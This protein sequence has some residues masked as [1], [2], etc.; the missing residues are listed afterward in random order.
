M[1]AVALQLMNDSFRLTLVLFSL[2]QVDDQINWSSIAED[3]MYVS[4]KQFLMGM[5]YS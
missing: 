5:I 4:K 3:N 2:L 1:H